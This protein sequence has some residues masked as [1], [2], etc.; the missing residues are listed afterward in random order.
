M[1]YREIDQNQMVGLARGVNTPH[2]LLCETDLDSERLL[3]FVHIP[4]TAG[5]TLYNYL[6]TKFLPQQVFPADRADWHADG[7]QGM[8]PQDVDEFRCL[9]G[10]LYS[11]QLGRFCEATRKT[12]VPFTVLRHPE[13]QLLS[14]YNMVC[15]DPNAAAYCQGPVSDLTF[16]R[17]LEQPR[18]P[19]LFAER[20]DLAQRM[21]GNRQ[22]AHLLMQTEHNPF[23]IP[24]SEWFGLLMEQL[25]NYLLVGIHERL[26]Q[27]VQLLA[28]LLGWH[29]QSTLPMLN[30]ARGKVPELNSQQR[31]RLEELNAI[32]Y[33]LY[34]WA[35]DRFQHQYAAMLEE[36]EATG[37]LV[38]D[39]NGLV[40]ALN[41]RGDERIRQ[42]AFAGALPANDFEVIHTTGLLLGHVSRTKGRQINWI[43]PEP[44]ATMRL[45]F[46]S[47]P[48]QGA[49]IGSR[50]L[51]IEILYW[52][53]QSMLD[54]FYVKVNGSPV[55]L[56]RHQQ[57][58][59]CQF[60]GFLP[61]DLLGPAGTFVEVEMGTSSVSTPAKLNLNPHDHE[62]KCLAIAGFQ[63]FPATV[64][65]LALN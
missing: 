31:R 39:A 57:A 21:C 53:K 43:G 62:Q 34:D 55:A 8:R 36:L 28:F 29:C 11:K 5:T 22:S 23:L 37:A 30:K 41:Q 64:P 58:S 19:S 6:D 7:M 38:N 56:A 17:F 33:Q 25:E 27:S 61:E 46:P 42:R 10:H 49:G 15:N 44:K 12:L 52:L 4:K 20:P 24:E 13:A 26:E 18:F 50:V 60:V 9:R 45:A 54:N 32:D 14:E 47:P 65:T 1:I 40:T 59:A 3:S 51:R 16:D 35:L 2:P 63:C 48:G